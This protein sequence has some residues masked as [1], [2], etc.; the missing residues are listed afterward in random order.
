MRCI[1]SPRDVCRCR[2]VSCRA[3]PCRASCR[4][5]SCRVVFADRPPTHPQV[6][7]LLREY[8]RIERETPLRGSAAGPNGSTDLFIMGD[9]NAAS[10]YE[11]EHYELP[12]GF[13]D[14]WRACHP[15]STAKQGYTYDPKTNPL[16]ALNSPPGKVAL[17]KRCDRIMVSVMYAG[18]Y[19]LLWFAQKGGHNG[20]V[21]SLL[22][23]PP[24]S[25]SRP[26]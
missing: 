16:A 20:S 26:P 3:V 22:L 9:L 18:W 13:V 12:N 6:H 19:S 25:R 15:H 5:V 7:T 4:V 10:E 11:D 1:V 24:P 14:V 21:P 2:V 23:S 8:Q 17:S